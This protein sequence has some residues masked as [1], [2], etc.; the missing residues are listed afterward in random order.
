MN[1]SA[2]IDHTL[3]KPTA[4]YTDI[5]KICGEALQYQF[6]AVCIPPTAVRQARQFIR[7]SK[8]RVATVIGFPFGYSVIKAKLA[9]TEQAIADEADELDIVINLMALK[10]GDW[11]YLAAEM[12]QLAEPAHAK[13]KLVKVIIESGVLTDEEIIRCCELYSQ[14]GVDFLKT[15]TGYAEKG[16]SLEA[17]KLMRKHLPPAVK[18][19]ASGGIRDYEFARQ[20]I[21]AGASR[22]G[23]SASVA[24]AEGAAADQ[25]A[26]Y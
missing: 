22:L 7:G 13:G 8:I 4:T 5:K 9:E 3:L 12:Q 6:A 26:A 1:I 18:I 17:V 2:Y 20:L 15:S 10:N 25:S 23:C 21:D 11:E 16:A 24:I 14:T 19:K